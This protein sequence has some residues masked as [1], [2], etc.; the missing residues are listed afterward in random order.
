MNKQPPYP[1]EWADR[2]LE[3]Y[4]A[5]QYLE[6]VQGDLHEWFE[7]ELSRVGQNRARFRYFVMVFRYFSL[8]RLKSFQKLIHHPNYLSMRSLI[9]LTFRNLR[10]DKLSGV[11]RVS[12]L[13]LG[14]TIFLLALVYARYELSYDKFHERADQI[15]RLGTSFEGDA[16]AATPLGMGPYIQDNG[17]DVVKMARL[18]PIRSTTIRYEDQLF[19]E[20]NGFYGDSSLFVMFSFDMYRGDPATALTSPSSIVI[21]E[22]MARKYFGDEDP[23]GKRIELSSDSD[24]QGNIEPRVVTGVIRDLPE[25]SH[26]QFDFICSIY[27]FN[28]DFSRQ[29]RNFWVYTYVQ[30]T[31]GGTTDHTKSLIKTEFARLR[32]V[33]EEEMGLFE[34]VMTPIRKIHLY[35]NHEKEYADNGNVYYVYILFSIGVFILLISIINFVNLTVIKGLDR[36]KEVGIRK[37]VGANR[38]QLVAQFLGENGVLLLIA[39]LVCLLTLVLLAP[40]FRQFS[41]LDLPLNVFTSPSIAGSLLVILLVTQLL[42]GLYPALILSKFQPVDAIK[43][44]G[45]KSPTKGVGLIRQI[46]MIAQFS[47]SVVLVIGSLVVYDQLS[48][49]QSQDLGFE[50]DQILLIK[51]DR[52]ITRKF[53]EFENEILQVTGVKSVSTS[54]SVPGY[55]IMLEGMREIGSSE[56]FDSRLLYADETFLETF[57]IELIAGKHFDG[58]IQRGTHEFMFNRLAAQQFFGDRNPINQQITISGDTGIVVGVVENFNFQTLHAEVEPLTISNLPIA[59]FGYAS[60]KYEPQA[61]QK[62]LSAI[63]TYSRQVYPDLPPIEVEFLDQR[64]EQLYL[65]ESKLL[66]IVWIFCL[67]TILLTVSG[68]FGVASYHAHQRAKEIAIRK[69]LGGSLLELMKQLSRGFVYLLLFA[70]VLGLP[71]AYYLSDWWLQDFAYRIGLNPA[72]FM[73]AGVLMLVI[74]GLTSSLVTFKTA[75][76]DPAKVLKSE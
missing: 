59:L 47:I 49:I 73:V 56:E 42:S 31:P 7:L 25:Q 62:V 61:T 6:E 76:S 60:I 19:F 48:F 20:K 70:L 43:P 14:I 46:L 65:S 66:S 22:S 1:P 34:V 51:L 74:I 75:N 33:P 13:T 23:M 32:N 54:S 58:T 36:A 35:T 2:I 5:D 72:I 12:N 30:L 40:L 28:E 45:H 18:A 17:S 50:K 63:D 21:T 44:G 15:Y 67:L 64:F 53:Q 55:R 11:I 39:G 4:C 41:G 69:V 57:D 38:D 29:W 68:I 16:W 52:T 26:L 9:K 71:G 8:F 27:T 10:R 37:V 3:W 24:R